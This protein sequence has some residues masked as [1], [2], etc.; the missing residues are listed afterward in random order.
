MATRD[1]VIKTR[2]RDLGAV[3]ARKGFAATTVAATSQMAILVGISVFPTGG[4]GGVRLHARKTWVESADLS[5]LSQIPI[6]IVCS[7]VKSILDVG[8]ILERLET[9]NVGV[10]VYGSHQFPG[11]FLSKSG[12]TVD[13]SLSDPTEITDVMAARRSFSIRSGLVIAH[14]LP[15]ASQ[16]PRSMARRMRYPD[17]S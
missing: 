13:W 5:A 17:F 10:V 1:H 6:M 4:L 8:A 3:A 7:G 12:I 14:P 15:A 11:F 16:P 9:L 2:I